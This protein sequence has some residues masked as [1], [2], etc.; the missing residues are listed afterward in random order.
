MRNSTNHPTKTEGITLALDLR[1][2]G[3]TILLMGLFAG[4]TSLAKTIPLIRVED[5]AYEISSKN[6]GLYWSA[7]S[8]KTL[9]NSCKERYEDKVLFTD[10][11][12][13][14]EFKLMGFKLIRRKDL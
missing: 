8:K 10:K 14:K 13:M 2:I 5:R 3:I 12:R 6:D 9:F 7:C 4:C 1:I 11:V